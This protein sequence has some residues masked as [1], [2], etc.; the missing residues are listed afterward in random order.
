MTLDQRIETTH[1][2]DG[3]TVAYATSG[4]GPPLLYLNGW[5]SHL[6]RGWQLPV[7]RAFYSS[8]AADRRLIRYDRPGCGLSGPASTPTLEREVETVSSVLGA[9][10]VTEPVDVVATSLGVPIAVRWAAQDPGRV[11]RLVLYG[12]MAAGA[13][14]APPEVQEQVIA[15]VATHWGYGSDL[16]TDIFAPEANGGTR[17][18]A[19]A[20][21][22][23]CCSGSFV[24]ELLRM[25]Y[26]VDV[27]ADLRGVAAPTL[28]LHREDDRVVPCVQARRIADGIAGARLR[29]LPGKSHLPPIG[30]APALV[31]AI[32]DFLELPPPPREDPGVLTRRQCEVAALIAEGLTNREIG[33]AL[34]ISERS[35]EG[36]VERMRLRLGVRSRAQIAAWWAA[37]DR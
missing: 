29:V 32:R 13:E 26:R 12:G 7:E 5:L 25:V 1:L 23:D 15:L 16:V 22:R 3:T 28:V 24:A 20:Y 10:D 35:A 18:A 4:S 33:D 11:R 2:G 34:G 14:L 27:T 19:A 21:Q 8:M 9:V 17:A 36:H 37:A 30:D 6:E 31:G